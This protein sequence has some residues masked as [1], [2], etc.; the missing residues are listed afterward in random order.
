MASV[1][2]FKY[3]DCPHLVERQGQKPYEV[4]GEY[5]PATLYWTTWHS[6]CKKNPRIFKNRVTERMGAYE[7]YKDL[8]LTCIHFGV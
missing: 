2:P 7:D 5:G 6:S 3:A 4:I 1:V 8:D